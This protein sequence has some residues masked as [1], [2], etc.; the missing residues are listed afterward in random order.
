[1]VAW[2]K[3]V[4]HVDLAAGLPHADQSVDGIYS[5]HALE[6]MYLADAR[7]LLRECARVLVP[8]GV[9][10]LALPDADKLVRQRAAGEVTGLELNR[11]LGAHPES[12]PK[13]I[14]KIRALAGGSLHKWQPTRDLVEDL[15]ADAGFTAISERRM[16]EGELPRLEEVEF[17][18][19]S[20]FTEAKT[21]VVD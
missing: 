4:I 17:R 9:L 2:P 14:R 3:N 19:E 6:H 8:N 20:F 21:V 15:L 13:G 7:E 5:S 16:F 11:R 1:M 18:A 10:R 12:A